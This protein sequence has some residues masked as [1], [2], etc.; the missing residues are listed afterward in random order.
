MPD[1][2]PNP[3]VIF[4][5]GELES[6]SDSKWLGEEETSNADEDEIEESC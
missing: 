4:M 3:V 5:P 1:Q 6:A 2:Q